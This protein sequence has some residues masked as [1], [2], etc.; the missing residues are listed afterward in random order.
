MEGNQCKNEGSAMFGVFN[1][2]HRATR[3]IFTGTP[4]AGEV[5]DLATLRVG[6]VADGSLAASIRVEMGKS[7]STVTIFRDNVC[8]DM[9]HC[10]VG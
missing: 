9:V 2:L 6:L 3:K 1:L 5:A 10:E 7:G 8:V 4:F